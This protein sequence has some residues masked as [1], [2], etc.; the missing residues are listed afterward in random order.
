M[1]SIKIYRVLSNNNK[2]I[3]KTFVFDIY[4]NDELY[5]HRYFVMTSINWQY[6]IK[7]VNSID[8]LVEHL[9]QKG[10]ALYEVSKEE[11]QIIINILNGIVLV[12]LDDNKS[13]KQ[14][15]NGAVSKVQ[16][17]G[18]QELELSELIDYDVKVLKK[19]HT[20]DSNSLSKGSNV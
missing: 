12:R 17:S 13:I 14:T 4:L 7:R 2:K 16:L 6:D 1:E 11:K 9:E 19:V 10:Y 5:A 20:F 8:V 3:E 15:N 18:D